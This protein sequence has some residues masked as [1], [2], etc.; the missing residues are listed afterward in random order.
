M[1]RVKD[2]ILSI[3]PDVSHGYK[4]N[5]NCV[6]SHIKKVMYEQI[7]LA[8]DKITLHLDDYIGDNLHLLKEHKS[9]QKFLL[10]TALNQS[11]QAF[12]VFHQND[13]KVLYLFTNQLNEKNKY[14]YEKVFKQTSRIG[15][16]VRL[17]FFL[18]NANLPILSNFNKEIGQ[19]YLNNS[20][21]DLTKN[22]KHSFEDL[23][24]FKN[25]SKI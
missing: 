14:N 25:T 3:I 13:L 9:Q 4:W 18:L 7:S 11:R 2:V 1:R 5:K 20:F 24:G 6:I 19:Q 21:E 17:Y 16:D 8:Y 12:E 10:S 22:I 15:T 23:Y